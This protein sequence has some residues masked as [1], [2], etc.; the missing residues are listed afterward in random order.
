MMYVIT[1]SN[2]HIFIIKVYLFII[3]GYLWVKFVDW[4]I[5]RVDKNG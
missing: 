3:S 2:N 1:S 4:I 5:E